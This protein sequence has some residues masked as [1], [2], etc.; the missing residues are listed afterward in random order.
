MNEKILT[1][2]GRAGLNGGGYYVITSA[3]EGNFG[4]LL[5][6]LIFEEYYNIKLD[7]EFPD[8]VVVH[9]ID[10]NRT[11]NEMSNLDLMP[12]KE[13]TSMHKTGEK[14]HQY[15][16]SPSYETKLKQSKKTSKTGYY[17]VNKRKDLTCL[18]GF[19][20]VYHYKGDDG[21]TKYI[22]RVNLKDLKEKVLAEGLE[23]KIVNEDKARVC[24]LV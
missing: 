15:G 11:N 1:K 12:L 2:F 7:E 24:G 19:I 21:K 22:L 8:G 23:W 4:K 3:K 20:W 5:H 18:Q 6:R 16:K 10:R 13:H 9:H 14:H 17:H